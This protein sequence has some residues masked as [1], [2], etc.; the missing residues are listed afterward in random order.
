MNHKIMA[1]PT[2]ILCLKFP[3]MQTIQPSYNPAYSR[4]AKKETLV[5]RFFNWCDGQEQYRLGWLAVIITIHGC[6]LTPLTV[7]TLVSTGN[8]IAFW[9]IT[10]GAMAMA[11][12]T[13]LAAMPTK[14]TIPIFFLSV[15][16]DI[17]VVASSI[18][19]ALTNV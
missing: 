2:A 3:Y 5:A 18:V 14:V 17:A 12:I 15:L 19:I 4:A 10:I 1:D 8:N 7:L 6:V 13:N 11:L 16:I 9:G